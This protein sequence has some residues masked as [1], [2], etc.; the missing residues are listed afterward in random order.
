M[1]SCRPNR[2]ARADYRRAE[3]SN[4]A[5]KGLINDVTFNVYEEKRFPSSTAFVKN[6]ERH[7][8]DGKLFEA[9]GECGHNIRC[10]LSLVRLSW[11]NL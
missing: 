10:G 11:N 8:T 2:L 9:T 1:T 6:P 7:C 3:C 4:S 5:A